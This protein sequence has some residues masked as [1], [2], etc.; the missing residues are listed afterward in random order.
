MTYLRRMR[1]S[2]TPAPV[3]DD[4]DDLVSWLGI[5]AIPAD[6]ADP[7]DNVHQTESGTSTSAADFSSVGGVCKP[8]NFPALDAVRAFQNQLNRVGATKGFGKVSID[9][10]VG[11][12][13]LALFAK[14]QS[15]SGGQVMG[16]AGSCMTVAPD[17]D[18]IGAQIKTLADSLGAPANVS[19]PISIKAPTI[20]TKSGAKVVAPDSG[21]AGSLATMSGGVKVAVIG[22]VVG[23]GYLLL[24]SGRKRRK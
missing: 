5:P 10:E 18:V 7:T 13:T 1:T 22:G 14:V 2:R 6:Q 23:L 11:P 24:T 12:K 9:G 21:I 15:V 16:D 8:K 4:W 17:V 3:G 20:V 19:A